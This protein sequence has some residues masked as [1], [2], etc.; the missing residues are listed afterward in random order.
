MA[1]ALGCAVLALSVAG[2]DVGPDYRFPSFPFAS[3][4]AAKASGTPVYL[5]NDA[6]WERFGDPVL[7]AL[8]DKGLE[9]NLDL[10]VARERVIEAQALVRTV[11]SQAAITGTAQAGTGGGDKIADG[12]Q[13][14]AA[15]GMSWLFDP[16]GGRRARISA[17]TGRA[18][19]VQA[20]LDAARLL[21]LSSI[22]TSYID[23]RFFERS[24]QL[25]QQELVSRN[26]TLDLVRELQTGG[27]GTRLDVVRAEAL[28]SQTRS[29]IPEFRTAA[30]VERYRLAVLLGQNPGSKI[31]A[32][33]GG[34]RGQPLATMPGD[35]GIPADLLRNRPDLR[36]SERLYYASVADIGSARAELYPALSLSGEL[37][38]S[39]IAGVS[40]MEYFFGPAIRLPAL[41]DGDRQAE[42]EVRESRARA[43]LTEWQAAVLGAVEEVES[44]L[45]SY[46][47]SRAAVGSARETV[48]L[49][50]E[51]VTLTQELA[52]RDGATVRDLLDDERS[53]ATANG[54]LAQNLRQLGR[55]YVVLNTSLGSGYGYAAEPVQLA[56]IAQ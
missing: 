39:S 52:G 51:A 31:A 25:R 42:V 36:I 14:E 43:A 26:K 19:A 47:G 49:Y 22:A 20:E 13:A 4:Y 24:L 9:G 23:L 12:R 16:Y 7:N 48:R 17:A 21:L 50:S 56:E 29:L 41:P 18:E 53:V 44:A 15:F 30:Q 38:L 2:C 34:S 33:D 6:W 3:S 28:V 55:T 10:A 37:S 5:Q 8:I 27:A 1:R 32:L 54:L 35:I 40:G 11:P 45:V 46:S